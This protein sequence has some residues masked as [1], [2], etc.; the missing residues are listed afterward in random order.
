[1]KKLWKLLL[2]L[3]ACSAALCVAASAAK[4]DNLAP[5]KVWGKVSPWGAEGVFLKN[6][7]EADPFREVVVHI[8]DAPVVD[9]ATGLPLDLE[10]V[11][12]GDTLY[13]WIGPAATMSLPPQV[14]ARVVV[15]NVPADAACPE[16]YELLSGGWTDPAGGDEIVFS[17]K[18]EDGQSRDLSIPLNAEVTPWLTRQ[19]IKLE[20]ID[21][22]SQILVW[23]DRQGAVSRVLVFPYAY[24]GVAAWNTEA[25]GIVNGEMVN[26]PGKVIPSE[27]GKTYLLPVRAMAEAAGYDVR[28]DKDLG[29]VVSLGGETVFSVKPGANVIQT[30]DGEAGLSAFCLLE[31][32]VTYL[33]AEDLCYWLNLFFCSDGEYSQRS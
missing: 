7:N 4:A 5:T 22:G 19:I 28:W 25:A 26:V 2:A 31:D 12:E 29:A 6:D 16:Y 17:V 30:P 20:S 14:F 13:A 1:M 23:R 9:A 24:R 27:S 3:A 33:P 18:G 11:K 10:K 21:P 8:G 32:G 15:G